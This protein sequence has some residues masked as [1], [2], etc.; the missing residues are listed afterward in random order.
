MI[1][2][3]K[4]LLGLKVFELMAVLP[5]LLF[6]RVLYWGKSSFDHDIKVYKCTLAVYLN[7]F[8]EITY[9]FNGVLKE[10]ECT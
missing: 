2:K 8:L 6:D 3:Y 10:I 1:L 4:R 9:H 7:F 5:L